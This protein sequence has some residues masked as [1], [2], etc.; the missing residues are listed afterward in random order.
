MNWALWK[1]AIR[2]ARMQLLVTSVLLILFGWVFVWLIGMFDMGAWTGL[3]NLLPDFSRKMLGISMT[4]FATPKGQISVLYMHLITILL[5]MGWA[6]GRGSD[7][8]SGEISRGTMD[9]TLSLPVRR[10]SVLFIPAVVSTIGAVILA[11]ALLFG[12]WLGLV[13]A[14]PDSHLAITAFLPGAI[15]LASLMVCVSGITALVSSFNRSRWRAISIVIAFYVVSIILQMVS[16]LWG[17]GAWLAY[18]SFLAAY[19]PQRLILESSEYPSLIYWYNGALLG[20]GL[21]CYL[22]AA[23]VFSHRDI[24]SAY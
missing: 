18:G 3:L 10:R 9:L 19:E 15:N 4:K 2:A 13:F 1:K 21:L 6:V 7:P 5:C 22:A 16:R 24:P 11:A 14:R 17:K 23:V 20:V 12:N 8:I